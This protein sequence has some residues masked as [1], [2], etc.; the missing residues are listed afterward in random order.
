MNVSPA[1]NK[2][3]ILIILY[4]IRRAADDRSYILCTKPANGIE[5]IASTVISRTSIL[6]ARAEH[7]EQ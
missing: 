6:R 3:T 7:I 2:I 1:Q 4:N 5:V